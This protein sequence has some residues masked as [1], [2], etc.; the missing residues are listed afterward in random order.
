MNRTIDKLETE[1]QALDKSQRL[2]LAA[3]LLKSV[4]P[5]DNTGLEAAW[6]AETRRR[7]ERYDRGETESIPAAEVFEGLAKQVRASS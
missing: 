1:T 2:E 6:N 3:R 7:I 4:E 5:Q